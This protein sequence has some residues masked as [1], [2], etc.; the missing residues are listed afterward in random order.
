MSVWVVVQL[1]VKYLLAVSINRVKRGEVFVFVLNFVQGLQVFRC[2]LPTV[3]PYFFFILY[4]NQKK[5]PKCSTT[6]FCRCPLPPHQNVLTP[7]HQNR[8]GGVRRIRMEKVSQPIVS[9]GKKD[10]F[11]VEETQQNRYT[12]VHERGPV[13]VDFTRAP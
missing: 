5:P 1:S 2:P 12:A 13:K 6:L 11:S 4:L 7:P 8:F 9:R 10:P 3:P